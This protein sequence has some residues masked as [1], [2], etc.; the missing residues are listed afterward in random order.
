VNGAHAAPERRAARERRARE[1]ASE[2]ALATHGPRAHATPDA[3][4]E[5]ATAAGTDFPRYL[6]APT[7]GAGHGTEAAHERRHAEASGAAGTRARTDAPES[8]AREE[9]GGEADEGIVILDD[10]GPEASA[11]AGPDGGDRIDM[12][13]DEVVDTAD[14]DAL[15]ADADDGIEI[16]DDGE[17]VD[18]EGTEEA[19]EAEAAEAAEATEEDEADG[20]SG[21]RDEAAGEG[22][23]A[24]AEPVGGTGPEAVAPGAAEGEAAPAATDDT[25]LIDFELAEHERWAGSFGDLGTARS[26]ERAAFVLSQTSS[27]A[28]S[29][30]TGGLGMGLV[31]G[32]A[33]GALGQIAGRRLATLAVS[34]GAT[35]VPVPGLGPAI[36]GVMAVAG[37]AMRDWGATFDTIG[38]FGTGEG[39]EGLANDLEGL[40]EALDLACSIMDVVGGVCGAIAVGMWVGTVLSGGTLAPLALTL[41]AIGTGISIATA[42]VGVIISAAVRPA[43]M[44]LRALHSF[45]SEADPSTVEADAAQLQAAASQVTG[46]VG[47]A[48]G[49][50]VG[51]AAGGRGGARADRLATRMAARRGGRPAMSATAG[52]GPRI[53][54]EVPDAPVRA[55]APEAMAARP[56]ATDATPARP[57]STSGPAA[58]AP[59]RSTPR[60]AA[61]PAT[62]HPITPD[63][64]IRGDFSDAAMSPINA[65]NRG[66]ASAGD[67]GPHRMHGRRG[68]D[69][70]SEHV[71]PG[72]QMRDASMDPRAGAPDW[73]R[74]TPGGSDGSDYRNA[75]TIVE[76]A[77]VAARKTTLDNAATAALQA[78]GGPRNLTEDLLLPSLDRH[79]RATRDAIAA[80]EI[81]PAQATDPTHRALA[82]LAEMWGGG[83]AGGGARARADAATGG[84]S[85]RLPRDRA[86][87]VE[88]ERGRT[89]ARIAEEGGITDIDW[90]ATFP[91][92]RATESEVGPAARSPARSPAP[93]AT[94]GTAPPRYAPHTETV[95]TRD[96]AAAM[97][98]YHDQ[99]RSDPGRE[100][101]VWRGPDGTFYV[102]Q[103]DGGSVRPPSAPGPLELVYHSH[104]T[105]AD[106]SMRGLV[107]QPSQANGDLGVLAYQHGN[108]PAGRR[109]ESELHFPTYDA[110]GNP[111]GYGATR[112]AYDPLSP[113]PLQVTTT[114]PG[115]RPTTQRY[116]SFADFEA[117]TGIRA[118]GDTPEASTSARVDADA[119]LSADRAAAGRRVDDTTDALLGLRPIVGA[120]EGRDAARS[121][122]S[123]PAAEGAAGEGEAGTGVARGPEYAVSVAGL[124]PGESIELPVNPA[125]PPPPGTPEQL[126]AFLDQVDAARAAQD[127]LEATEAEMD[128]QADSERAHADGLSEAAG[129]VDELAVGREAHAGAVEETR[130]ANSDMATQAG[131][132]YD[133]LAEGASE[134]SGVATLVGSLQAFR[135][136]AHLFSYLPGSLGRSAEGARDDAG[137]LIEALGRVG[138]TDAAQAGVGESQATIEADAERLG[139]VETTGTETDAGIQTGSDDLATLQADNDASLARTESVADLARSE[140]RAAAEHEAEAQ[141]G[142]DSLLAE[143]QA[144]AGLHR[145]ARQDAIDAAL[146]RCADEGLT[147]RALES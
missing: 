29:G 59:R 10:E 81:T 2:L 26:D 111:S 142:H 45:Q 135:G 145:Q 55:A 36:G 62:P 130:G 127:G 61:A 50:R 133:A 95:R 105:E 99:I 79:E 1:R 74:T 146:A 104:P 141:A 121:D 56:V 24:A 43:V 68:G 116:E 86:A 76:H 123:A 108:G 85:A 58:A 97:A 19:G 132:A 129:V 140:G 110:A 38:R 113:L 73:Q 37:L 93:D 5:A 139:A 28:S 42:A 17:A 4:P 136:M 101:G 137:E 14:G 54:A 31:M 112:F 57:A 64:V 84:T 128:A 120:R 92:H 63:V 106:A 39:Y 11:D 114:L 44:A 33:G 124:A 100:S 69:L 47:G 8:R 89:A 80:G 48:I 23:E 51:G 103:G 98:Q 71:I 77:A 131:E 119:R 53:H 143:L 41:S 67:V 96:R 118:G 65:R 20:G 34:R 90:D 60:P 46:A 144:W 72:A 70:I 13:E 9:A 52:P 15:E 115:G 109:V 126:D 22:E 49:G 107:S 12:P 82:A 7:A 117:R 16:L 147:A 3:T 32:A 87:R 6:S 18:A 40:A 125:Y 94:P 27:G 122:D 66:S 83:S 88:A 35:A 78:N 138:E 30:L 91:G 134:A 21:R 75:T 102:M 25:A